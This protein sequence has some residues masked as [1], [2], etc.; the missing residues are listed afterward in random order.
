MQTILCS[1]IKILGKYS[2]LA[3]G[4]LVSAIVLPVDWPT[5]QCI[6]LI[7]CVAPGLLLAL[8]NP[9]KI[10][11]NPVLLLA[12]LFVAYFSAQQ[13]RGL[14]PLDNLGMLRT[15][16][17]TAAMII[18]P[19]IL[20]SR[21]NP[22]AKLFSGVLISILLIS[23]GRFIL[24]LLEFYSEA[25]FPGARF[26][27]ITHPVGCAALGGLIAVLSGAFFLQQGT[28]TN[29]GQ[30]LALLCLP[31][32]LLT[33]FY[34]HTRS[35]FLVL[36]YM[37]VLSTVGI[38][39]RLKKTLILWI[40]T[41]LCIVIYLT[42]I[43]TLPKNKR[44]EYSRKPTPNQTIRAKKYDIR[45]KGILAKKTKTV[46]ARIDIWE[47]HFSRMDHPADWVFGH[48]L[49]RN[50]FV[51]KVSPEAGRWYYEDDEKGYLQLPHSAYVWSLYFGGII[52]LALLLALYATAGWQALLCAI[53]HQYYIPLATLLFGAGHLLVNGNSLLT[54]L[55]TIYLCFWLPIGLAAGLPFQYQDS[56]Q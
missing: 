15:T 9:K 7:F 18:G 44:N 23:S 52:G 42:S 29:P 5:Y 39:T 24:S 11:K 51:Q 56:K 48:G 16:L 45:S 47:D 40:I 25:P 20:F 31:V 13:L 26:S 3:L 1:I 32:A 36:L 6:I 2:P 4:I 54:N 27:G 55:G 22:R 50:V 38:Q 41:F 33:T 19:L 37:S 21:I 12:L 49:G 17:T 14:W 46:W 8:V 28:K 30:W 43:H 34:T 53:K 35:V 10:F